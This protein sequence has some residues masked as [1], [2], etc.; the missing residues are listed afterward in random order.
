MSAREVPAREAADGDL[1]HSDASDGG[2]GTGRLGLVDVAED[3]PQLLL[4]L[5]GEVGVEQ[6]RMASSEGVDHPVGDGVRGQGE[7]GGAA[8]GDLLTR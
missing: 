3:L 8:R 5:A 1:G 7:Q 6:L 2:T 4:L